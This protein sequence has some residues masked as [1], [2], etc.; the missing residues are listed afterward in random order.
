MPRYYGSSGDTTALTGRVS[1]LEDT[2]VK[3]LWFEQIDS[4]TSG[5]VTLPSG[6]SIV[7][8]QWAA[9]VDALA[10]TVSQGIPTFESPKTAGDETITATMDANGAYTISDTPSSY[11]V[12]VVY[13]YKVKLIDLDDTKVLG[14]LEV[15]VEV[16]AANTITLIHN[17]STTV[18][19]ESS[20]PVAMFTL[21]SNAEVNKTRVI[22]DTPFSGGGGSPTLSIGISGTVAKYMG[23]TQIDLKGEAGDIYEWPCS[24][25]A[26]GS[27]EDIIATLDADSATAGSVRV[28]IHYSTPA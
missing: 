22:I 25:G 23:T 14:G 9:G 28:E 2:Y 20:S 27:P 21:P 7:L 11:P 19:F 6:A 13:C 26:S 5:S 15:I 17:N 4:G 8:D 12:A 18:T 10:S 24:I 1:A 16:E 3:S